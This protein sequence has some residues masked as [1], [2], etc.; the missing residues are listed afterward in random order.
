MKKILI[1]SDPEIFIKN[2]DTGKV[3]S[4]IGKLGGSKE[5]PLDIGNNC[6]VQEDNVL[7][8]FNIPPCSTKEEFI[9]SIN[10]CKDYIATIIAGHGDELHYS[11]SEQLED[12]LLQ[13][14]NARIFGCS[15]SVNIITQEPN[16]FDIE[17]LD[18]EDKKLRSSGFHIHF[19]Y[20]DPTDDFN[21]RL[22]CA[23][24]LC[25][26]LPLISKDLDVYNRRKMYGAIGDFRTKSY[27]IECRS[28]GGYFLKDDESLSEVWDKCQEAINLANNEKFKTEELLKMLSFCVNEKTLEFIPESFES[29]TNYLNEKVT[30]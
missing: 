5:N 23:F 30:I 8:E 15:P 29:I 16:S 14:E 11:S 9:N 2:R 22:I 10:Y 12:D 27:G 1:G 3:S 18:E 6:T 7:A 19:G 4:I 17:T 25:V 24:E 28:L 21:D 26:T 13:N 20:D